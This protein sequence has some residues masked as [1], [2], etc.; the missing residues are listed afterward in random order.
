MKEIAAVH[1]LQL[2]ISVTDTKSVPPVTVTES[3]YLVQ[4]RPTS[5]V[6][7]VLM[8]FVTLAMEQENLH[9]TIIKP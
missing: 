2:A 7:I 1:I 6:R 5:S 8:D 4:A 9:H 3:T